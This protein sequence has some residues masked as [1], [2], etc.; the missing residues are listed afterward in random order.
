MNKKKFKVGDRVIG[1]KDFL[2]NEIF[3]KGEKGFILEDES[4]GSVRIGFDN[5]VG[6]H[7]NNGLCKNGHGWHLGPHFVE[8]ID[9]EGKKYEL[10]NVLRNVY[11]GGDE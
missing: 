2:P 5:D 11:G 9:E 3:I 8:L 1:V 6:G 4:S 10:K 7:T